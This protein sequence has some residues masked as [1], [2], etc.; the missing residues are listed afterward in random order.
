VA[1]AVLG[2]ADLSTTEIY[3]EKNLGAARAVMNEIG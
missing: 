3:A 1:Q 2:H